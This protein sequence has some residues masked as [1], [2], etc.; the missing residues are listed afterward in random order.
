[1]VGGLVVLSPESDIKLTTP[2]QNSTAKNSILAIKS[3]FNMK[4][5]G[6]KITET[7]SR[8]RM[9][10]QSASA[11]N[12]STTGSKKMQGRI[13]TSNLR[14]KYAAKLINDENKA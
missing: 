3:D 11:N 9:I 1:M 10:T 7:R 8:N 5:K 2:R 4:I 12:V 13:Y 14:K 6:V